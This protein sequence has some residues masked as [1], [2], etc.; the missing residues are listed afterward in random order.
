MNPKQ[1]LQQEM[2]DAMRARDQQRVNV[3]RMLVAAFEHAQETMGKQAFATL[4]VNESNILPDRHQTLS[5]QMVQ[6]IIHNEVVR[7]REAVDLFYA[8]GQHQRA[9][10][11]ESEIAILEN[12]LGTIIGGGL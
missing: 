8:G 6:D 11:E 7:R 4:N 5:E 1:R 3:F 2:R 10:M 12:Y 9:A